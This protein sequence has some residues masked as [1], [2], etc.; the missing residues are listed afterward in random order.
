MIAIVFAVDAALGHYELYANMLIAYIGV[1]FASI[2]IFDGNKGE[3]ILAA[4]LFS[5]FG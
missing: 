2:Y 3:R 1:V 5:L 4:F